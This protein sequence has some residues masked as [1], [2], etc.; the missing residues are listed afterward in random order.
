MKFKEFLFSAALGL[1]IG[2]IYLKFFDPIEDPIPDSN[3]KVKLEKKTLEHSLSLPEQKH[4]PK[5]VLNGQS[6]KMNE[7]GSEASTSLPIGANQEEDRFVRRLALRQPQK[8]HV[9]FEIK[10]GIAITQGDMV[11]G[12]LS[13]EA[14]SV[15]RGF[16]A[17]QKT[18]LWP[19]ATIP[20]SIQEGVENKALIEESIQ[21]F[22]RQTPIRFVPYSGQKDSL[23]FT[24]SEELCASYLGRVGGAQ[25]IFL[26]PKCGQNEI[27]HELMHALGFVHEHSRPDRDQHL[28]VNWKNIEEKYWPQFWV[29]P[30]EYVHDFVGS[31][32]SFDPNSIMLYDSDAFAI[33]KNLGSLRAKGTVPLNPSRGKLSENDKERVFYLY[34]H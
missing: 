16:A 18:R 25:P 20:Y 22:Q 7:S 1:I 13:D 9:E 4:I 3:T 33:E 28:D 10:E 5:I 24:K 17:A 2:F 26:S 8:G 19:S 11:L 31:V 34:G 15:D 14:G 30:D 32:F 12:K 6:L 21:L 29:I 27:L 23:V